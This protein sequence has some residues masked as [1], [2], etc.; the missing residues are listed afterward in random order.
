MVLDR[1]TSFCVDILI[2]Y[3]TQKLNAFA[4]LYENVHS[5]NDHLIYYCLWP[6]CKG[7]VIIS[8]YLLMYLIVY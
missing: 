7:Y 3:T 5:T 1:R 2:L 8:A 6:K 4:I